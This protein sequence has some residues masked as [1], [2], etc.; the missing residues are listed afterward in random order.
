MTE[1][2]SSYQQWLLSFLAVARHYRL[3]ISEE[4]VRVFLDWER[5]AAKD[6]L[7]SRMAKHLGLTLR[8]QKFSTKRLDP[9]SLPLVIEF[10]DD[11]VG[12]ITKANA[13]GQCTILMGGDDGLTIDLD[14]DEVKERA[15]RIIV[16]RPESSVEDVRVDDYIKPF[17]PNW[18]WSILFKDWRSYGHIITA[19]FLINILALASVVFSMQVYDRVIPAQS[20]P[21]LWVLFT[22]VALAIFFEFLLRTARTH[23]SDVVGK[24]V[25]LRISDTV[26]GRSL[27]LRNDVRPQS[28]G[29]FVSQLRELDHLREVVASSTVN[30]MADV[31]FVLLFLVVLFIIGGPLGFVAL[32]ALPLLIL[33]GIIAQRPLAKLAKEGMREAAL[34]NAIMI[35]SAEA[36][37][38][39]KLLR[40]EHRFQSQWNQANSVSASINLRQRR[41]TNLLLS[42]TQELQNLTFALVLL[43]GAYLVINGSITTGVL[44]GTSILSSRMM[45]P[46]SQWAGVLSRLQQ[47]KTAYAGLTDLMNKPLDQPERSKLLHR[48]VLLGNYELGSV[49]LCYNDKQK[50]PTL[51]IKSLQIKQGERIGVLGKMGAGKS[52]L[53]QLLSGMVRAQQGSV[54]LDKTDILQIDPADIRRDVGLLTQNSRLLFGSI[55]EN[56]T[57]GSPLASSEKVLHTLHIAGAMPII[58]NQA[59]G[60]D[61]LVREGGAGLSGGQKQA[62]LLARTLIKD[63]NVLLLD[64]P[65]ASMDEITEQHVVHSLGEWLA[66]RTLIVATHKPALLQLVDRIIVIDNGRIVLDGPKETILANL[67]RQNNTDSRGVKNG[68]A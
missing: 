33:P 39:I 55:R 12:V 2:N 4:N 31:P 21:T 10:S 66:N 18:F 27:R 30:A 65:T 49:Q 6:E 58:Q 29:S 40:A 9:W 1:Q 36:I 28:T 22:G 34:R 48:P 32:G 8:F 37:E 44:V 11:R 42:W 46:I 35:E 59:Q 60:I 63:P 26:F 64:E 54:L 57:M 41:I 17:T 43:V 7:L 62:L 50:Q 56:I 67:S 13:Q 24:K 52:T 15:K 53:L 20:E 5:N 51:D 25:D 14:L 47:A 23:V 68:Q 61:Y 19:S 38:D 3:D 45:G 16:L